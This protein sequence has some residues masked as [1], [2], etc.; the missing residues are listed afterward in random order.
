MAMRPAPGDAAAREVASVSIG[1]SIDVQA[2]VA[3]A[4]SAGR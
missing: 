1:Q 4:W 2:A 3:G